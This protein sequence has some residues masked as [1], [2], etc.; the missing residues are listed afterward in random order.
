MTGSEFDAQIARLESQWRGTYGQERRA[1]LFSAFRNVPPEDFRDAVEQCLATQRAA[2]LLDVLT[3]EVDRAK[4]RRMQNGYRAAGG[5]YETVAD[6]AKSNQRADREF[7]RAC[8]Q[9]LRD[10]LGRKLTME[11][12]QQGCDMLDQVADQISPQTKVRRS[13]VGSGSLATERRIEG[14]NK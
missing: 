4:T 6:A 3:V 11:Q 1:L 10:K 7:V 8:L 5:F 9:L 13:T 14:E 2:P 12:F